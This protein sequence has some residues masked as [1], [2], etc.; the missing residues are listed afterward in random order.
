MA[1]AGKMHI[2]G[3]QECVLIPPN[4][5]ARPIIIELDPIDKLVL[6]EAEKSISV[7]VSFTNNAVWCEKCQSIVVCTKFEH[8]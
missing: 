8:F 1:L 3:K 5:P 7:R 4:L 2:S 6:R